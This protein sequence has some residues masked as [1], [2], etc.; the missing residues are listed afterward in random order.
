MGLSLPLVAAVFTIP[1]LI[2]AL[3]DARFGLLTLIWA[4]VSYFGLFDLGFGRALTQQLAIVFAKNE[5][6]KIGPLVGTATF[7]MMALGVVAALVML[8]FAQWTVNLIEAVPDK[9]EAI[10]AVYAMALA[11][12]F[13]VLTS[14]FRGILE[15]QHAFGIINIIR[16]PMG[17]FTFIGPL[18]VVIFWEP[19]IDLIAVVLSIGR[20][21]A[22]VVHAYF[23]WKILPAQHGK[24]Q[25]DQK[26]LKSLSVS[27]GWLTVSN[28]VSPLMTYVDRFTIGAVIS[29]SAVAYYVTPQELITKLWIVP[30]AITAVLFPTFAVQIVQGREKALDLYRRVLYWLY[31]TMLPITLVVALF[32]ELIL[33]VWINVD[34]AQKSA[35]LLQIFSLGMFVACLANIPFTLLQSADKARTTAIFHLIELPLFLS[36]LWL[37]TLNYGLV[38]AAI[39]WLLRVTLDAVLMFGAANHLLSGAVFGSVKAWRILSKVVGIF[40]AFAGVLIIDYSKALIWMLLVLFVIGWM[41]YK[42]RHTLGIGLSSGNKNES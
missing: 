5:R 16:I 25:W 29:A 22:C 17:L 9:Q 32:A 13:I 42:N 1:L 23:A 14:G 38:G 35:Q 41:A 27:G 36:L 11:M 12:P 31:I 37:L 40:I 15:A 30:G 20:L 26:I 24:F 39:A 6:S 4:I 19:R 8:A 7:I 2:T 34:F 21:I 3:G 10:Y 33:S 28:I 18:V